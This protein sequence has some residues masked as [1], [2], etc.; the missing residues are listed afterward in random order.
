MSS[1]NKEVMFT[2]VN[3]KSGTFDPIVIGYSSKHQSNWLG[4]VK[5]H[6]DNWDNLL[7]FM[8]DSECLEATEVVTSYMR[9]ECSYDDIHLYTEWKIPTEDFSSI[10]KDKNKKV[11][12]D[13][14][15]KQYEI[16]VTS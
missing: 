12:F 9:H 10:I 2:K 11:H 4:A 16:E 1:D 5:P 7:T 15:V 14:Y 3:R 13:R 6:L 8:Q